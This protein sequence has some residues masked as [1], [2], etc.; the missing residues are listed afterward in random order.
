MSNAGPRPVKT[1]Q[2]RLCGFHPP[3]VFISDFQTP[4][5][6]WLNA[7]E[8][9]QPWIHPAQLEHEVELDSVLQL[10]REVELDSVLQLEHEVELDSVLQLEHEVELDS[11]LQLEHEVELDSVLQL[12]HEVKLDSHPQL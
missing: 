4:T 3:K 6:K 2:K 5:C 11:V 7:S 1:F 8:V 10:E 9:L 12:E